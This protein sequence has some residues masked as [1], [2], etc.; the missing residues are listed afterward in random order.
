[1]I[2]NV[3]RGSKGAPFAPGLVIDAKVGER[4]VVAVLQSSIISSRYR[5]AAFVAAQLSQMSD[6]A[7]LRHAD[8]TVN[9]ISDARTAFT[10]EI[11]ASR[12]DGMKRN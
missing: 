10:H 12:I 3:R 11:D 2:G 1:V 4:P 9:H 8:N 7:L 6:R 5:I